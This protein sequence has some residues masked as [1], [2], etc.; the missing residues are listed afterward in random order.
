MFWCAKRQ[1]LERK[2]ANPHLLP[3][4]FDWAPLPRRGIKRGREKKNPAVWSLWEI[5]PS[6]LSQRTSPPLPPY[7]KISKVVLLRTLILSKMCARMCV[8]G[9][10]GIWQSI[11][12]VLWIASSWPLPPR[13]SSLEANSAPNIAFPLPTAKPSYPAVKSLGRG[14]SGRAW[15]DAQKPEEEEDGDEEKQRIL[16]ARWSDRIR[17][18]AERGTEKGKRLEMTHQVA[19]TKYHA[20]IVTTVGGL[21]KYWDLVFLVFP[22]LGF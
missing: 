2:T 7:C 4:L 15:S 8:L 22:C 9:G 11:V 10:G 1:P 5:P 6:Q 18:C 3:N 21:I 14:K 20:C 12:V 13:P 17:F 19:G 16:P